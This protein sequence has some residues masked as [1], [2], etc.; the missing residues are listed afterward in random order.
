MSFF[1]EIAKTAGDVANKGRDVADIA[2]LKYQISDEERKLNDIYTKIGRLY[3]E[4]AGDKATGTLATLI[5]EI[6]GIK[7]TI[8]EHKARIRDLKGISLCKNCGAELSADA[9]F[10]VACGQR[11]NLD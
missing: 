4:K 1:D 7:A 11:V 8:E 5:E 9:K 10:C 3:V 6:N 2:R